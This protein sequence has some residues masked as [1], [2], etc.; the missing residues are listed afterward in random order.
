MRNT[1]IE[2]SLRTREVYQLFERKINGDRLFIQTILHKL[3][4]IINRCNQQEPLALLAHQQIK[5]KIQELTRQFRADIAKFESLLAKKKILANKAIHFTVQFNPVIE[6]TNPL[7]MAL[8]ELIE[9]YDQLVVTS[10]LLH[11]AGCFASTQDHYA[12]VKKAQDATNQTLSNILLTPII[13]SDLS[14][15]QNK[16]SDG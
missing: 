7:S 5:Q 11:F 16:S 2:L 9:A 15:A 4:T 3:N 13:H 12:H 8:I 1:S 6:I 14:S 10:K